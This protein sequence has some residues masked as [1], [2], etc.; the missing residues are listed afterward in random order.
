MTGN[1]LRE[2]GSDTQQRA[3]GQDS[4]P[5][6]LQRGQSLCRWDGHSTHWAK[7][8]PEIQLFCYPLAKWSY[9]RCYIL[10]LDY[11]RFL[12]KVISILQTFYPQVRQSNVT[13]GV[14]PQIVMLCPKKNQ[15]RVH[16]QNCLSP[17]QWKNAYISPNPNPADRIRT[18]LP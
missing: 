14:L 6:P 13:R 11:F 17:D 8:G 2:R 10:L 7:R 5:G 12:I 3:P 18:S 15:P 4:K 9:C 1:R 16:V